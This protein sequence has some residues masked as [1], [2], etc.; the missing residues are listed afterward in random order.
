M[1]AVPGGLRPA[2]APAEAVAAVRAAVAVAAVGVEVDAVDKKASTPVVVHTSGMPYRPSITRPAW[3]DELP[4][5]GVGVGFRR[6][7]AR[8]IV[9][10]QSE[11][12]FL[13]IITEHYL[14]PTGFHKHELKELGHR[15]SLIPHG[16]SLSPGTA[17]AAPAHYLQ[18]VSRLT[19]HIQ[20]PWWSD[21]LAMSRVGRID[22]GHLSPVLFTEEALDIVCENVFRATTTVGIPFIIE[23]IAYTLE[24]PG[25]QMSEGEFLSRLLARTNSGLLLDLMN[26]YANSV[27]HSYDPYEFL[28]EIPL[29][30]VVQVHIIGGHFHDGFLVDSHSHSTPREVW[31]MLDYVVQRAVINAVLLEWDDNFPGIETILTELAQA[32]TI[33]L[34]RG[35]ER[36]RV[37]A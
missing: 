36:E 32:K 35:Y 24:L 17:A 6:P 10:H 5:L 22:I 30:R 23:N 29:E 27:N 21:H 19:D 4:Q 13:E 16:L 3:I 25:A 14:D 7:L 12:D 34:G 8:Q 2:A 33:L 18:S 28:S 15:F 31:K 11:I 1:A 37:I 20:P 9:D 26:L